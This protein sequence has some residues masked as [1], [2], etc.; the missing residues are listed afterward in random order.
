MDSMIFN[1][2]VPRIRV[3]ET[4]LL[5]RAKLDRMIDSS[6]AQ[7]ALRVLQET[8]YSAYMSSVKRVE[9]YEVLL[10][11][12]LKRV[13]KMLFDMTPVKDVVN[14]LSL[15]YDYHNLKTIIKAHLMKKDLSYL[16]IS[17]GSLDINK[18][19]NAIENDN[20]RELRLAVREAIEKTLVE[21][22]VSKDPQV[23]DVMLDKYMYSEMLQ[24]A[25]SLDTKFI[26]KYV[27]S[28]IDLTNIRTIL[29]AKKQNKNREFFNNVIIDGGYLDRDRLSA[30]FTDSVENIPGKLSHTDYFEIIKIGIEAYSR[31]GEVNTLEKLSDDYLMKLIKEGKFVSFGPEPLISYLIAKETEIKVIRIVMVGK[32]NKVSPELIRERL[33]DIYV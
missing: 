9:D 15:R 27:K 16:F 3:L 4:R 29:R 19:I 23:I 22:N 13:Y 2:V 5:D 18:T 26:T 21:F 30:L 11:E 28:S 33:R 8:E 10:K 14:I 32:L 24:I 17:V 20:Y 1:Q 7:E 25:K 12:E 6:S 31:A